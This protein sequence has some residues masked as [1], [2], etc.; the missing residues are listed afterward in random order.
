MTTLA[1]VHETISNEAANIANRM[2]EGDMQIPA[3]WKGG[4]LEGASPYSGGET[5][6][7][8]SLRIREGYHLAP[9]RII[10][11]YQRYAVAGIRQAIADNQE[12]WVGAILG[13][14]RRGANY[15]DMWEQSPSRLF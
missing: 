14:S 7:G 2:V 1:E 8:L 15:F 12:L 11:R 6:N 4:P 3:K 10:K 13:Q 5:D 9:D